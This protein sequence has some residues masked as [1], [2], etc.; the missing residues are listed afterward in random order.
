LLRAVC[1][2]KWRSSA[3]QLIYD[4]LLMSKLGLHSY[5]VSTRAVRE[6]M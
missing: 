5:N 1:K 2:Y 3:S 6:G 4:L